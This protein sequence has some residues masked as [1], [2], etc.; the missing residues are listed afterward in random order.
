MTHH[1]MPLDIILM[2]ETN[3]V[4]ASLAFACE[5]RR[6]KWQKDFWGGLDVEPVRVSKLQDSAHALLG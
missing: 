6:A 5:L 3:L 2:L 1:V 4:D